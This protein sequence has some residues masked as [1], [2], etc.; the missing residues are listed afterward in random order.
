MYLAS[1]GYVPCDSVGCR[2]DT[3]SAQIG[4]ENACAPI[5]SNAA[6]NTHRR[7]RYTIYLDLA[8]KQRTLSTGVT[9]TVRYS[10]SSPEAISI[11][12]PAVVGGCGGNCF[13]T[14]PTSV[15]VEDHHDGFSRTIVQFTTGCMSLTSD[16]S[17]AAS[18]D[19]FSTCTKCPDDSTN[20][21][22][23]VRLRECTESGG[24]TRCSLST[25]ARSL[26]VAM[27]HVEEPMTV[28]WAIENQQKVGFQVDFRHE[29]EY[30]AAGLDDDGIAQN[31]SIFPDQT[32]CYHETQ[33]D[34]DLWRNRSTLGVDDPVTGAFHVAKSDVLAISLGFQEGSAAEAVM[35]GALQEVRMGRFKAQCHHPVFSGSVLQESIGGIEC[36]KSNML[37]TAATHSP[38]AWIASGAPECSTYPGAC[39]F[40]SDLDTAK[41]PKLTLVSQ[42]WVDFLVSVYDGYTLGRS[43]VVRRVQQGDWMHYSKA[44]N[45]VRTTL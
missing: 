41:I 7:L 26:T 35:V 37:G 24:D 44:T 45:S 10:A 29:R 40:I 33:E 30:D 18:D 15:R 42:T 12:T 17:V 36:T 21:D 39:Q 6:Q 43:A 3:C 19:A 9:Q 2:T 16:Q 25:G 13:D 1:A 11:S 27:N 14:L 4:P 34:I 8:D 23:S 31:T 32:A 5:G 20:F 38:F 22:F 28:E